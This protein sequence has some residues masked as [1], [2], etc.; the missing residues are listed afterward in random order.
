MALLFSPEES[1]KEAGK[2][3]WRQEPKWWKAGVPF[4][5][6]NSDTM[7]HCGQCKK[8]QKEDLILILDFLVDTF[9][10]VFYQP[11]WSQKE[12]ILA[13]NS[14]IREAVEA[15]DRSL[16]AKLKKAVAL[17]AKKRSKCQLFACQLSHKDQE[18]VRLL[19]F[20]QTM[21][22]AL[23][24]PDFAA[25]TTAIVDYEVLK[26]WVQESGELYEPELELRAFDLP[27]EA[28]EQLLKGV[29]ANQRLP[30]LRKVVHEWINAQ[31]DELPFF[32][33]YEHEVIFPS[34]IT[35]CKHLT[36]IRFSQV[37]I[38]NGGNV[39]I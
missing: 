26:S 31:L 18:Y 32:E 30:D 28:E 5:S 7:Q 2:S 27:D 11:V 3:I 23:K 35:N 37:C 13:A 38:E 25:S 34:T 6:P 9:C 22:T 36:V 17:V 8:P 16:D 39:T 20:H 29:S 4:R 12:F 15:V 10:L 21:R 24:N 1:H 33:V 19:R 14:S